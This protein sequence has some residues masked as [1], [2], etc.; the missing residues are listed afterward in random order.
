[1]TAALIA[2]AAL[3]VVIVAVT[4]VTLIVQQRRAFER[5]TSALVAQH[6]DI[7]NPAQMHLIGRATQ[8]PSYIPPTDEV[9]WRPRLRR[10]RLD[11]IAHDVHHRPEY[12]LS[13]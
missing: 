2:V 11:A 5:V 3:L 8:A 9:V 6:P 1:M 10:L 12:E 4:A 7:F 13:L